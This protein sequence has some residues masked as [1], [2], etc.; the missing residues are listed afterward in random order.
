MT[1][2]ATEGFG[3]GLSVGSLVGQGVGIRKGLGVGLS[4]WIPSSGMALER[5]WA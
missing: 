3:V 2:V 5:E 1:L 4:S